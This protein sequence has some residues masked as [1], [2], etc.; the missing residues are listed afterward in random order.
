LIVPVSDLVL[1]ALNFEV[2]GLFKPIPSEENAILGI[3]ETARTFVEFQL[4]SRVRR[5]CV[6]CSREW[7]ST[8]LQ[9]VMSISFCAAGRFADA[10]A[11][12]MPDDDLVLD[13]AIKGVGIECA[14]PRIRYGTIYLFHRQRKWNE[15]EGSG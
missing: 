1:S 4:F 14:L 2:M 6:R 9:I 12:D 5:P 15:M 10:S 8:I 13:C 3:P 11:A 7:K